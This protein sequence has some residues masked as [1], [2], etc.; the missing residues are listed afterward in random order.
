MSA[1]E[2]TE[3]DEGV[4]LTFALQLS[5]GYRTLLNFQL[6]QAIAEEAQEFFRGT[7]EPCFVCVTQDVC[8]STGKCVQSEAWP[9][10]IGKPAD[11]MESK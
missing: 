3:R 7:L 4:M 8:R 9:D 1:P 6:A 10:P 2:K 5:N 11:T